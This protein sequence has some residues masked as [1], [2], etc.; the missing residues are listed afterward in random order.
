MPALFL[1]S[2]PVM[3]YTPY[4]AGV[5]ELRPTLASKR[6]S[7]YAVNSGNIS[8]QIDQNITVL[9]LAEVARM[10]LNFGGS[11]DRK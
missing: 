6:R 8:E 2:H 9:L 4:N 5:S 7:I 10:L 3:V 11:S 1:E